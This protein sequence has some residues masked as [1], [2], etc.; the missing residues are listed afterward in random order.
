M[1]YAEKLYWL[2]GEPAAAIDG[3]ASELSG[4]S[5]WGGTTDSA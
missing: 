5:V 4:R 1:P 2:A 3:H